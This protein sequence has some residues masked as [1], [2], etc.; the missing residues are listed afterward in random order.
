LLSVGAAAVENIVVEK[1]LLGPEVDHA[2]R[3]A[4]CERAVALARSR[5]EC[6]VK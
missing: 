1:T 6:A 5:A 3:Q 4:A 2:A